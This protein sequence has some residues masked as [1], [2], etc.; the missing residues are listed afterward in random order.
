VPDR[1]GIGVTMNEEA[2]RNM[3]GPGGRWFE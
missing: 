2:V 3:L 1:P